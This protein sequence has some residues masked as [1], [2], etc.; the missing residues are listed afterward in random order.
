MHIQSASLSLASAHASLVHREASVSVTAWQGAPPES[1]APQNQAS[2]PDPT[3]ALRPDPGASDAQSRAAPQTCGCGEDGLTPAEL[4]WRVLKL[5]LEKLTGR[6]IRIYG[7][8]PEQ[9]DIEPLEAPADAAASGEE[10]LQGWGVAIEAH[11][12]EIEEEEAAFQASGQVQ[13]ADGRTLRFDLD[14]LMQRAWRQERHGSLLFGD[15]ARFADPLVVSLTDGPVTLTERT[16]AFDLDADGTE[17]SIAFV[18]PG[19]AFLA[20]DRNADGRI[21][22]GTELFGPRTG[23]GFAEL[24][25]LDED[26]NGWIDEADPAFGRLRLWTRPDDATDALQPLAQAGIGAISL[27]HAATPFSLKNGANEWLG[28][29]R[30]S[31]V[32]LRENGQAGLVQEIDLAV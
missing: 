7:G 32:Y 12:L 26:G 6:K 14:V 27:D 4:K 17:E 10:P 13:T 19:A 25:D 30:S 20:L 21:N 9:R 3:A 31:G 23:H 24:A 15:A 18:A 28:R 29:T 2:T 22:D 1:L 16:H 8:P 11:S 5:L